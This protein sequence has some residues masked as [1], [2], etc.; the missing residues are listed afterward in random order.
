MVATISP[1]SSC[2]PSATGKLEN[3]HSAFIVQ[4]RIPGG[5]KQA[6]TCPGQH[7]SSPGFSSPS[8]KDSVMLGTLHSWA[9]ELA[10][11]YDEVEAR[12]HGG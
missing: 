10:C 4:L 12:L 7:S 9:G 5:A 1:C 2:G 11:V 3:Y 8:V 6:C